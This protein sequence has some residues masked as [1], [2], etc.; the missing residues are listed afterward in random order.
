MPA[1][2]KSLRSLIW[3]MDWCSSFCDLQDF[4]A[5]CK[6]WRREKCLFCPPPAAASSSPTS[7]KVKVLLGEPG[8]AKRHP[9]PTPQNWTST[10]V[11]VLLGEPGPAK[12]HLCPTPQKWSK[13]KV[14][15]L[16]N[17]VVKIRHGICRDQRMKKLLHASLI[18]WHSFQYFCIQVYKHTVYKSNRY[19]KVSDVVESWVQWRSDFQSGSRV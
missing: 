13:V 1:E 15:V 14:K 8:P 17:M 19:D 12:R 7:T 4:A 18:N 6:V 3:D 5:A 2:V 11:K 10:K 9:C 16:V